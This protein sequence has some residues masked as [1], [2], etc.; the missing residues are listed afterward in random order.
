V[1]ERGVEVGRLPVT[2]DA[3]VVDRDIEPPEALDRGLHEGFHLVHLTDITT[4]RL[5]LG[6]AADLGRHRAH[7]LV[8][9]VAEDE[10]HPLLGEAPRRRRADPRPSTRDH[11]DLPAES[12]HLVL[13]R[14]SRYHG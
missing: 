7:A 1:P 14:R 13:R 8:V 9:E 4:P 3:S 6:T 12:P 11:R 10:P 2:A 5:D